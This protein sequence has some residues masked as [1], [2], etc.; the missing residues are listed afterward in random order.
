MERKRDTRNNRQTPHINSG[1]ASPIEYQIPNIHPAWLAPVKS[2]GQ[3]EITL[4]DGSTVTAD[5]WE[6]KF[7][8]MSYKAY[9]TVDENNN[10]ILHRWNVTTEGQ[11]FPNDY[12][13]YKPVPAEEAEAFAATFQ[14]PAVCTD[15]RT[16]KC[17]DA[18]EKGLLSKKNLEF[19]RGGNSKLRFEKL[20]AMIPFL[21]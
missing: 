3:E 15:S 16:M 8:I 14:E 9:T 1:T 11:S 21:K 13:D 18:H 5:V 6:W 19:L 20:E 7:V 10:T 2:L 12:V 17:G 4:F